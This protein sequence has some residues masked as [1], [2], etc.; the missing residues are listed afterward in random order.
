LKSEEELNGQIVSDQIDEDQNICSNTFVLK[1]EHRQTFKLCDRTFDFMRSKNSSFHFTSLLSSMFSLFHHPFYH[2]PTYC[3]RP[4]RYGRQASLFE[5]YLQALDQ[6]FL[7]GLVDDSKRIENKKLISTTSQSPS[8]IA[9][10][11]SASDTTQTS[12]STSQNQ[13]QLP[14]SQSGFDCQDDMEEHREK[15]TNP[16]GEIRIVS[17]R[18]L[19]DR[20]YENEILIDKEGKRTER[21][22]W[23]NVADDDIETFKLEWIEKRGIKSAMTNPVPNVEM[24]SSTGESGQSGESHD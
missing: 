16:D 5:H 11:S 20:W 19:G 1:F 17:R 12:E 10:G 15:V 18:R 7:S 13:A 23:H 2:T 21:E 8:S 4:S 24:S 6:H 22:T 14:D 9:V 3:I